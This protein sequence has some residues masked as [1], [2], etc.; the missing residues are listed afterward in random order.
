MAMYKRASRAGDGEATDAR[1]MLS[2]ATAS[3]NI[4]PWISVCAHAPDQSFE[5][6]FFLSSF[7]VLSDFLASRRFLLPPQQ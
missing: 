5:Q 4:T 6:G 7:L 2:A 1:A 3:Y